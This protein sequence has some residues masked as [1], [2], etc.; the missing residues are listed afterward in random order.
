MK[1]IHWIAVVL[2][3]LLGIA[4]L[5]G[6]RIYDKASVAAGQY[7]EALT[8][9]RVNNAALT[10]QISESEAKVGQANT[11]IA[12]RDK[13]IGQMTNTIGQKDGELDKIRGTW[14]KLSAECVQKLQELDATWAQKF[15]LS[16]AIIAEKDKVISAWAVKFDAQ[17]VISESWKQKYD[18]ELHL[19]TL[20]E[21]GW[22]ASENKLRW[23]RVVGN[24]KSG[25]IVGTLG[26]IGLN[27]L[28]KGK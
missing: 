10:L 7:E 11:I 20:A 22:K 14:S 21:K 15:S 25:L 16:E 26:Y 9:E 23:A 12:E 19:R 8:Q 18:S 13:A 5:D 1:P 24:I 28:T 4:I 6:L 17:V 2:T 27:I 3:I